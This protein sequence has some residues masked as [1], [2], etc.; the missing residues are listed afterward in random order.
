MSSDNDSAP[1]L[2]V[3]VTGHRH[4]GDD[5]AVAW[6]VHARCALVLDRLQE[7]ARLSHGRVCAYS[8]LAVGADQLFAQAALGLGLPLVGVVPFEDY[9]LDFQGA[10]RD[11]YEAILA[12]CVRVHQLPNKRR[13]EKAYFDAGKWVANQ[14]DYLVAVWNGLPAAGLGGTGD[15]VAYAEKKKRTVLRINPADARLVVTERTATA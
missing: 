12:R 1:A 10:D 3:G 11:T 7:L 2:R 8:A 9:P 14:V 5:P 6:F 13:S 15:V 4:L